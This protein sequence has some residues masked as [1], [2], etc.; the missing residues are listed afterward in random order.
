GDK[1]TSTDYYKKGHFG[2]LAT[3]GTSYLKYSN[4][5]GLGSAATKSTSYFRNA[6]NLNAGRVPN[7]RLTGT[8]D[9]IGKLKANSI[10]T[11]HGY[12][13]LY[14]M[15]QNVRTSDSVTHKNVYST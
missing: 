9:K 3:K 11:G 5:S 15:N 2:S 14:K 6:S 4:V 13:Q 8:Y 1:F 12:N 10:S 7:S